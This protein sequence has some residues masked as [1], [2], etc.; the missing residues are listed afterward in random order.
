MDLRSSPCQETIPS[1]PAQPALSIGL[2]HVD[3][4]IHPALGTAVSTSSA[5][6]RAGA[7]LLSCAQEDQ[8]NSRSHDPSFV[9]EM[10]PAKPARPKRET[11]VKIKGPNSPSPA[12]ILNAIPTLPYRII[13]RA[14]VISRLP[15]MNLSK[16]ILRTT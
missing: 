2:S 12:L 3:L 6:Q 8:E 15:A 1:P 11:A 16:A 10:R 5:P 7:F 9:R 13:S 14:A 4:T